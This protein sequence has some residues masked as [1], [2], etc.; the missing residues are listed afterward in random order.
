MRGQSTAVWTILNK[1]IAP[2]RQLKAVA[3]LAQGLALETDTCITSA[4]RWR[5]PIAADRGERK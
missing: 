5:D 1:A 4:K 2:L 3:S